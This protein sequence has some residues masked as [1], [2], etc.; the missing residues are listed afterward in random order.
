MATDDKYDRQLRLWGRE[1]Q[2]RLSTSRICVLGSSGLSS[3]ILK[4]LVLPGIGFFTII[5]NHQ[6]TE[7]D[8]GNNFF[9]TLNN[10]SHSRSETVKSFLLELNSDVHGESLHKSFEE[11]LTL[12]DFFS[13]FDLIIATQLKFSQIKRLASICEGLN[14][15]LIVAKSIGLIGY[16]RVYSQEHL[17]VESKPSDKEFFDLRLHKPFD[18]LLAYCD[19]V[20]F[21]ELKEIEH[22]HVP[23]VVILVKV[24]KEWVDIHGHS[25]SN[26]EEK[27]RFKQMVKSKSR[28][29]S[30]ELNFQEACEKSYLC[31]LVSEASEEVFSVLQDP[32]SLN[33][34]DSSEEFW[35]CAR[36][37]SQFYTQ[38][39]VLPLSGLFSDMTSDTN[40]YISLQTIYKSKSQSDLQQVSSIYSSLFSTP[41][42]DLLENFCKNIFMI[43][44]TRY[45]SFTEEFECLNGTVFEDPDEIEYKV[46]DWYLG[47]RVFEDFAEE[48]GRNAGIDDLDLLQDNSEKLGKRVEKDVLEEILRFGNS[49]LHSVSALLGGVASQEVVKLVTKQFSPINNTFLFTGVTSNA[50]VFEL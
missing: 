11:I 6:I 16:L 8:L 40:S 36:S 25:P 12:P 34:S 3:E 5:D 24:L 23:F 19:S 9:I 22:A 35:K 32:K 48:K 29:Y 7:S 46:V 33:A 31:C 41:V 42:P 14:K 50:C 1:G 49:E 39:K 45:R 17:V 21:E 4:N 44:V 15:T 13:S 27:T 43:E 10:L 28:N 30:N 20:N 47:L 38:N 2:S 26:F 18:E 37:I